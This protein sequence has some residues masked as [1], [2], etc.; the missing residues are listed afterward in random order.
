M[1]EQQAKECSHHQIMPIAHDVARW[2][3]YY[4]CADCEKYSIRGWRK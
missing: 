3:M 1:K 2:I 4:K